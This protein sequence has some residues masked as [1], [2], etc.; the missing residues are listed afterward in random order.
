VQEKENAAPVD[1]E[2][3]D[4][5]DQKGQGKDPPAPLMDGGAFRSQQNQ[6]ADGKGGQARDEMH[7][8][9]WEEVEVHGRA[10]AGP[11]GCPIIE[12]LFSVIVHRAQPDA[13]DAAIRQERRAP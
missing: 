6:H 12:Y 1:A 7:P 13:H 10:P 9:E 2:R 4:A 8:S 5:G 11:I 3:R